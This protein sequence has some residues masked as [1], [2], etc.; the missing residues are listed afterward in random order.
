[1]EHAC[2]IGLGGLHRGAE[3]TRPRGLFRQQLDQILIDLFVPLYL[4]C[5]L[6]IM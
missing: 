3:K 2:T 1:M 4:V 6:L 5:T